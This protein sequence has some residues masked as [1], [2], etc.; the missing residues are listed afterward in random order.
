MKVSG[1]LIGITLNPTARTKYFLIA[2]ELARLAEQAKLMAGTS[3]NT[4][5]SHHN[6]TTPVRLCEERNVQQLTAS[7]QC[8]TN[9]FTV[10]DPDL[11]NLVT[12]VR[13]PEKVK[14]DLC[15]QSIIG[16][17][18]LETFVKERIQTAENSIWDVVK[19]RKLLTW[20]TTGKTV[21]VATKDKIIKLKEDRC[22]F[23]RNDGNLQ[24]PSRDRHQRGSGSVR[25]L[26]SSTINVCRRWQDAAL[27]R[28]ERLDGYSR[29]ASK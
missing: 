13:M 12:K 22:L 3:S 11:F 9:P 4:Q 8:F 29:E 24:V 28:K 2:P 27:F 17:K 25:V 23:A 10:E 6:L 5:T 19:K 16:N 18:L 21:R 15:D 20:K 7:I 26:G 1:G 14:K